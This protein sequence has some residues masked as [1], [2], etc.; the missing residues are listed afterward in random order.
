MIQKLF[1]PFAKVEIFFFKINYMF[2]CLLRKVKKVNNRNA[3]APMIMRYIIKQPRL[4]IMTQIWAASAPTGPNA[5]LITP[6][7]VVVSPE[8]VNLMRKSTDTSARR[9]MTRIITKAGITPR[10]FSVAGIDMMPAPIMLV[11]TLKTAP[12]TD[13]GFAA[14]LLTGKRGT[15]TPSAGDI[16][17]AN[18]WGKGK[19]RGE[20][21]SRASLI[22]H[23]EA[24]SRVREVN[25]CG[26]WITKM[27]LV[28]T[29]GGRLVEGQYWDLNGENVANWQVGVA[30]R[31]LNGGRMK[32]ERV[33]KEEN[34]CGREVGHCEVAFYWLEP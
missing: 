10:T 3:Y 32:T 17:A 14:A 25:D 24:A 22:P 12:E 2:L 30:A 19:R 5:S 21:L 34:E 13:A 1:C 16:P 7:Y 27:H 23:V 33:K 9:A 15:W 20:S 29:N 18:L 26:Y 8:C 6:A 28:K 31:K 4:V 11:A